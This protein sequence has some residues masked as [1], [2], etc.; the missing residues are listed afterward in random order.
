MTVKK[1]EITVLKQLKNHDEYENRNFRSCRYGGFRCV[2]INF[3]EGQVI[4]TKF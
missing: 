3:T 2:S 1:R 4:R